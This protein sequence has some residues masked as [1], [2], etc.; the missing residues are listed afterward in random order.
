MTVILQALARCA[1]YHPAEEVHQPGEVFDAPEDQAAELVRSGLAM[2]LP[3]NAI[4]D[5]EY[6][7]HS[8][9]RDKA[10]WRALAPKRPQK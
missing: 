1:T 10:L 3:S 2:P 5:V 6:H 4:V 7:A 8:N 9:E